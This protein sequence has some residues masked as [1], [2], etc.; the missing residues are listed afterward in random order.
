[1]NINLISDYVNK[2]NVSDVKNFFLKQDIILDDLE[3]DIIYN[4]IKDNYKD[5]IY[6]DI[7]DTLSKIRYVVK[8]LTYERIKELSIKYK[9]KLEVL[10]NNIRW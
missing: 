10:K 1:M 2:L 4:Y 8:P 6:D 3:I 5:I 7:N 9:D